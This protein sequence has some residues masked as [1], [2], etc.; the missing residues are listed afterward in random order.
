MERVGW[1]AVGLRGG[2]DMEGKGGGL[3][4]LRVGRVGVEKEGGG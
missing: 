2:G 3:R 4:S 1:W